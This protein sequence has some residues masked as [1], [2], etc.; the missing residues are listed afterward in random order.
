MVHGAA[1][2]G[3]RRVTPQHVLDAARAK[4]L[5]LAAVVLI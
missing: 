1:R 3:V 5:S 2:V 4:E